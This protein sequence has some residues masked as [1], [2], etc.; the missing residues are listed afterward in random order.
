MKTCPECEQNERFLKEMHTVNQKQAEEIKKLK[1]D[2][3]EMSI[4]LHDRTQ[5]FLRKR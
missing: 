2:I 1:A 3:E 4:R 5:G